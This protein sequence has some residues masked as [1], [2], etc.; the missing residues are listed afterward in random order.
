[1]LTATLLELLCCPEDHSGLSRAEP[2]LLAAVNRRIEARQVRN[3][4]GRTVERTMDEGLVRKNRD[5]LYPVVE[6]IPRL[7]VEEG[8]PLVQLDLSL[9]EDRQ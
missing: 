5:V 9:L 3:R 6:G 8:I 4:A 1:M 7:L 2:D